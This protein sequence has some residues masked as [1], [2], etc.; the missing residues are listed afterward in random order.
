MTECTN[1]PHRDRARFQESSILAQLRASPHEAY[2]EKVQFVMRPIE[3]NQ[4]SQQLLAELRPDLHRASSVDEQELEVGIFTSDSSI[5]TARIDQNHFIEEIIR[6]FEEERVEDGFVH[7]A[8]NLLRKALREYPSS[9]LSEIKNAFYDHL[10]TH[11]DISASL[12]ECLGGLMDLSIDEWAFPM[13]VSALQC[14]SIELREAGVRFFEI[15]G[16]K[17]A[18]DALLEHLPAESIPWMKSY[19][20]GVIADI[21]E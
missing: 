17:A 10:Q 18:I 21:S 14:N 7:P 11:P 12:L 4:Y 3:Q 6:L 20:E 15:R 13:A 16:G 8:E 5:P 19:I 1:I 2:A 9:A